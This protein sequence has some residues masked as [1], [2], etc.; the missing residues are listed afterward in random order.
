M[1][2][3]SLI[4]PIVSFVKEKVSKSDSVKDKLNKCYYMLRYDIN[5]DDYLKTNDNQS[6]PIF[7][8]ENRVLILFLRE[9]CEYRKISTNVLE[10]IH[11]V[12]DTQLNDEKI[13][14][15]KINDVNKRRVKA[16]KYG[17]EGLD[18]SKKFLFYDEY[19]ASHSDLYEFVKLKR[20]EYSSVLELLKKEIYTFLKK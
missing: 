8:I 11:Q 17:E 10:K 14:T 1:D 20:K 18:E 9:V 7:L 6:E 12:I 13:I 15:E 3:T 2:F 19:Y 5:I 16:H 4:D